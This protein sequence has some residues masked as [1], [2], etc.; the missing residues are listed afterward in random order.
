MRKSQD[1]RAEMSQLATEVEAIISRCTK[2]NRELNK[3]EQERIDAIQGNGDDPGEM[4][5]LDRERERLIRFEART[6]E[7]AA[8]YGDRLGGGAGAKRNFSHDANGRP[9]ACL[10]G[11]DK[12]TDFT[13]SPPIENAAAHV[14]LAYAFGVNQQTP[15]VV[16]NTLTSSGPSGGSFLLPSEMYGQMWDL[17]RPMIALSQADMTVFTMTSGTLSIPTVASDGTVVNHAEAET[18]PASDMTFGQ[19][20]LKAFTAAIRSI[21]SREQI[22]DMLDLMAQQLQNSQ[23]RAVA[24]KVDSWGLNGSGSNEPLGILNRP[25]I[26]STGSIGLLDWTDVSS[27]LLEVRKRNHEPRSVIM[28]P[29]NLERLQTIDAG[30]GTESTRAWLLEPASVSGKSLITTTSMPDDKIVVGD[31]RHYAMGMRQQP[32]L[33]ATSVGDSFK[34]HTVEIKVTQRLDFAP[35]DP[36]AFHILTGVTQS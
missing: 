2:E 23:T 30:T 1:A 35:L 4:A 14:A 16:R 12:L 20:L 10:R 31:F 19:T 34:T 3:S 25:E 29:A 17:A 8:Q 24:V 21:V 27:A 9:Y 28:S 36:S 15:E 22:E 26:T 5:A 11:Q 33:E 18:I 13:G 32:V 7:L 6:S